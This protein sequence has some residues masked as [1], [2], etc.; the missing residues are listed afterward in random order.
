D[1]YLESLNRA[2]T[3]TESED[4]GRRGG[5]GDYRF[6]SAG[7]AKASFRCGEEKVVRFAVRRRNP[8]AGRFSVRCNVVDERGVTL[9]QCDS[10]LTGY[11]V[12][13]TDLH[14]GEVVIRNPWLKPGE[15]T[16]DLF[17]IGELGVGFIDKFETACRFQVAN[18]L[19]YPYST[20]PAASAEGVVFADFAYAD[21]SAPQAPDAP[22]V[23]GQCEPEPEPSLH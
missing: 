17:V 2:S 9:L 8:G 3:S 21:T 1:H 7:P 16:V 23:S 10:R 19:P 20:I 5:N 14:E 15:Y 4:A 12:A 6:A 11:R 18:V 22:V 13:P